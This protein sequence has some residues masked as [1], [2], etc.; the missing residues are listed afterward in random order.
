M[1]FISVISGP[2]HKRH[3]PRR[4]TGTF[5]KPITQSNKRWFLTRILMWSSSL[6]SSSP[7]V[8]LSLFLLKELRRLQ[9]LLEVCE[10][11][12]RNLAT[13]FIEL[14][15]Q[16]LLL[17]FPDSPLYTYVLR[18]WR[19]CFHTAWI[20]SWPRCT[21]ILQNELIIIFVPRARQG[22]SRFYYFKDTSSLP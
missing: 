4:T 21:S 11:R 2:H 5:G 15:K 9:P 13:T 3:R 8:N 6:S 1:Q 12:E 10:Q 14:L 20:A 22:H 17:H 16:W 19:V 7:S 18:I